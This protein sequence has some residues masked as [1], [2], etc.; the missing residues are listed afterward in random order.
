MRRFRTRLALTIV[1]LVLLTALLLGAGSYLFVARSLR[2]QFAADAA[3]QAEFAI[4]ELATED[5]LPTGAG[6]AE[7]EDSGLA[8]A[9]RRRGGVELYVDFGAGAPPYASGFAAA[10]TPALVEPRLQE[11]VAAGRLGW[12]W[13][14]LG[15]EPYLVVGG[16][17]P[18][19]GPDFYIYFSAGDVAAALTRLWQALAVGGA[20]LV[21]LAVVA[22]GAVSRRVLH[23]VAAAGRA[24]AAIASGDLSA[25][26]PAEGRDEFGAWAESFNRMA[27]SLEYSIAELQEGRDRERRFVA[28]VSHE[29]RTPLTALVGEAALLEEHLEAMSPQ[30]RRLG[31]LLAADTARLRLLVEDLLEISRLDAGSDATSLTEFDAAGLAGAVAAARCPRA[32]LEAPGSLPVRTD[33]RRLERIL[34]NLL[35][36]AARHAGGEDVRVT[37]RR[38][39]GDL[40]V[41]VADRGP[42]VSEADLGRLFERFYKADAA[43]AASGSGLGL[44]IARSHARALGGDLTAHCREGGGLEFVARLPV[45]ELLPDGEAPDTAG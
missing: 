45:A 44:A 38:E 22:A 39:A 13:L 31:E 24:A 20:V 26:L 23:P 5:R 7:F 17:R 27:A 3:A 35:D 43:R 36:N 32:A 19:A 4:A 40:V 29:L 33:R 42:G 37:M 30:A 16:R 25:R 2:G 21:G 41:V 1:G 10:G 12:Q 14:D 11:I 34:G 6:L 8:E 18:E 28:D 9:I 15:G